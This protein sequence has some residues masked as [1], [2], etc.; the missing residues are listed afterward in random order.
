[1]TCRNL[2]SK[3]ANFRIFF[4]RQLCLFF[5]QKSFEGVVLDFLLSHGK[6]LRKNRWPK[7]I[8]QFW[9]QY[10]KSMSVVAHNSKAEW[11]LKCMVLKII[12][13]IWSYKLGG[14]HPLN[15]ILQHG[16]Q[17]LHCIMFFNMTPSPCTESSDVMAQSVSASTTQDTTNHN[18]KGL[19]S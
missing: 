1:V 5:P 13:Q 3:Y 4:L 8:C 16:F 15:S 12:D 10:W 7:K 17:S 14:N 6:H 2:L 11:F 9:L 18:S 19:M